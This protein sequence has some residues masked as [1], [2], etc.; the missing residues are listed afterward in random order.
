M[1]DLSAKKQLAN[2]WQGVIDDLMGMSE[3]EIDAEL[4]ELGIDPQVAADMAKLGKDD[5]LLRE[6]AAIR[7]T[8]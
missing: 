4:R 7:S 2:V 5:A 3:S 8:K 1:T 6:A